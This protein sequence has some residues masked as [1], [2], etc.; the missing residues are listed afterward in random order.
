M[1]TEKRS[2]QSENQK[3]AILTN[4]L[5]RRLKVMDEGIEVNEQRAREN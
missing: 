3:F 4:E 1:L 5:Q 2:S